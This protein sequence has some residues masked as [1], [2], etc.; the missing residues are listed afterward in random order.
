MSGRPPHNRPT[1]PGELL[2]A[3]Q[4]SAGSHQ[5]DA[6]HDVAEGKERLLQTFQSALQ[7][8]SGLDS[9][10][11]ETLQRMFQ[12]ALQQSGAPGAGETADVADS[13][14]WHDTVESLNRNGMVAQ[15][16]AH[17]LI[18]SLNDALAPLQ[19]R[20]SRLAMEFSRRIETEGR[21]KALEWFRE[22]SKATAEPAGNQQSGPSGFG[23]A[24]VTALPTDA[25]SSRSHRLRGPPYQ[26]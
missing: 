6:A 14:T 20:E 8:Q 1:S 9:E 2:A 5:A 22:A 26:R 12:E 18:R 10:D 17:H 24:T 15:E 13:S 16:E 4:S 11:R 21:E 19:R 23:G 25:I 3:R 7:Q